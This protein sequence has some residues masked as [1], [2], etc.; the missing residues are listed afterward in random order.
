M[1]CNEIDWNWFFSAVAQSTAAIVGIFGAFIFTKIINNQREFKDQELQIRGLNENADAFINKTKSIY[2]MWYIYVLFDNYLRG[3]SEFINKNDVE[4]IVDNLKKDPLYTTLITKSKIIDIFNYF[5][6]HQQEPVFI[7]VHTVMDQ[8]II[9]HPKHADE[10]TVN[11]ASDT[12]M[13]LDSLKVEIQLHIKKSKSF[14]DEIKE[15]ALSSSLIFWSIILTSILF[16]IGVI[17]SLH[18]LP[19]G[20]NIEPVV[21]AHPIVIWNNIF[22]LKGGLLLTITSIYAIIMGRFLWI[23]QTMKHDNKTKIELEKLTHFIYYSEFFGGLD[24]E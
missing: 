1:V 20:K 4:T 13:I 23:N 8:A 9:L 6:T 7:V 3:K 24:E 22:C 16:I 21:S 14:L 18:F 5:K 15:N 12:K 2:I 17:Y 11:T 19:L 10:N